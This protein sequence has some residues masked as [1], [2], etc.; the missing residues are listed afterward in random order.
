MFYSPLE[1]F[2]LLQDK[3]SFIISIFLGLPIEFDDDKF[4]FT[5]SL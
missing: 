3:Y 4:W 5:A 2:L 1:Q